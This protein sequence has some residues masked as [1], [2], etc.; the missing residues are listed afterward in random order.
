[1]RSFCSA[2]ASLIFSTKNINVFGYKVVKHLMSWPLNKLVKL[3][4]LWTIWPWCLNN[5]PTNFVYRLFHL[6]IHQSSPLVLSNGLWKKMIG[7]WAVL[8]FNGPLRGYFSLYQ[9]V[10]QRKRERKR[11]MQE[12]CPNNPT[13]WPPLKK[14]EILQKL[15]T[16]IHIQQ[17]RP[18]FTTNKVINNNNETSLFSQH[19]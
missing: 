15:Q 14:L 1:M 17:S 9:A 4:M 11:K 13:H 10:L 19:H 5:Y 3:K 7:W 16:L 18:S 2:K 8:G 12:K 6:W